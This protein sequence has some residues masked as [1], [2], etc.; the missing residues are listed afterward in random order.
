M[1]GDR[2]ESHTRGVETRD[3]EAR[4]T[5]HASL[6][7]EKVR[8]AVSGVSPTVPAG[9]RDAE[10]AFCARAL[11]E[12]GFTWVTLDMLGQRRGSLLEAFPR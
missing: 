1:C 3:Q 4:L 11:H 5:D 8:G 10:R 2:A 9:T 12:I 7:E 6:V